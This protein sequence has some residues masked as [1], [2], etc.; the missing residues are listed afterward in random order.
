MYVLTVGT[1]GVNA[2]NIWC[3][4]GAVG[5]GVP[6]NKYAAILALR[7]QT[8]MATYTIPVA[9][10]SGQNYIGGQIVRWYATV[11]AVQSAITTVAL[12]TRE[13]GLSW[14]TRRIHGVSE[15][16]P[17][18]EHMT[19]GINVGTKTDIRVRVVTNGANNTAIAAG[20]D[21]KLRQKV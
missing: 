7:G 2:G 17:L 5:A 10:S 8:L 6:A 14:R 4:S 18:D 19:F 11:G 1:G 15:G 21:L 20:F 9:S 3:G 13:F 12:E 16:G